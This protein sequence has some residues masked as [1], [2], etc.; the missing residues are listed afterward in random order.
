MWIEGFCKDRKIELTES[1][2]CSLLSTVLKSNCPEPIKNKI[3]ALITEAEK[4]SNY[5]KDMFIKSWNNILGYAMSTVKPDGTVNEN[6]IESMRKTNSWWL[7]ECPKIMSKEMQLSYFKS[8]VMEC[9]SINGNALAELKTFS[10]TKSCRITE[11]AKK[12]FSYDKVTLPFPPC[13]INTN[14]IK[15]NEAVLNMIPESD[16]LI[17]MIMW[18][19]E[20]TK[21][22]TM[23]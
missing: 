13:K 19:A 15:K 6:Q 1:N 5:S 23:K 8:L 22:I 4:F 12:Y 3:T 20:S 9:L 21:L 10:P 18:C 16:K 7:M 2:V 17:A 14:E 11:N